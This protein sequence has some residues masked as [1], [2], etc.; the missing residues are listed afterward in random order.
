MAVF[1][2][3][4]GVPSASARGCLGDPI[5]VVTWNGMRTPI[6]TQ[7]ICATLVVLDDDKERAPYTP[8]LQPMMGALSEGLQANR[9]YE[10][11]EVLRVLEDV[12]QLATDFFRP[13]LV[14]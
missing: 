6:S 5:D 14:S 11:V 4:T 3:A 2:L 12:A 1:L 10:V 9:E 8:L 7:A 13:H